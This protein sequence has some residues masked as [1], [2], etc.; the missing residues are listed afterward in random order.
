[1]MPHAWL[2]AATG[3]WLKLD[4]ATRGDDHF[5]PGPCDVAWDLAGVS[6]EWRLSPADRASLLRSYQN[7]SGDNAADRLAAYE[8]AYAIFRM[9]WSRMAATSVS[10]TSENARLM[11]DYERYRSWLQSAA[12][13]ENAQRNEVQTQLS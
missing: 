2:K 9:A 3:E 4:A 12:C 6:V 11:R 8:L 10:V 13:V 1:M 5:F 7:A